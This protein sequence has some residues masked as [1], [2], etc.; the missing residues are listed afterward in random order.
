[1]GAKMNTQPGEKWAVVSGRG[2]LASVH[3]E[4]SADTESGAILKFMAARGMDKKAWDKA[5]NEGKYRAAKITSP[6]RQG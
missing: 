3:H 4:S 2:M 1:M 6:H 5:V